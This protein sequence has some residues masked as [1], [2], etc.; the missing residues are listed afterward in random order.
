MW[1]IASLAFSLAARWTKSCAFLL[2]KYIRFWTVVIALLS[3]SGENFFG[4]LMRGLSNIPPAVFG[5]TLVTRTD[6]SVTVKGDTKPS[7][8]LVKRSLDYYFG[9]ANFVY[10]IEKSG[11]LRF[12]FLPWDWDLRKLCVVIVCWAKYLWFLRACFSCCKVVTFEMVLDLAS[13][14]GLREFGVK[15]GLTLAVWSGWGGDLSSA[16]SYLI[17]RIFC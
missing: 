13:I 14:S 6:E 3:L 4:V 12:E 9:A 5:L 1:L 2:F 15:V 7:F 16:F 8:W 11:M 17:S 10:T